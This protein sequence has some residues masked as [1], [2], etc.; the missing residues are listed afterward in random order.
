M[1]TQEA[2][3]ISILDCAKKLGLKFS[4]NYTNTEGL[5][6]YIFHCP[7]RTDRNAS[8]YINE[9]KNVWY[10]NGGITDGGG[11]IHFINYLYGNSLND[12]KSALKVLN[13]I[14]PE[15][16]HPSKRAGQT[17]GVKHISQAL[18]LFS[19][20]TQKS[21]ITPAE[22]YNKK[23]KGA[24]F[25]LVEVKEIFSYPLKNYLQEDRKINIDIAKTHI[26]EIVYKHIEKNIEFY[27]IGFKSGDTWVIR[28]KQFKGFLSKGADI[29]LIDNKTD[30]ILLFEGFIDFLSYLTAKRIKQPQSSV[31]VLNSAIFMNRA[32]DF[33]KEHDN[34]KSI[35]YFRDRDETGEQSLDRLEKALNNV[36][37][38]DKSE[39][40]PN[41]KDLNEWLIHEYSRT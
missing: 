2:F 35:D 34:I 21:E 38:R 15:L 10:D 40:Y 41:H 24:V 8:I 28:R 6:E 31:I 39:V 12:T 11:I 5:V 20:H 26:K 36:I 1:R 14:Y 32:I 22:S 29:T 25:K 16:K 7:L 9:A 23:E 4:H 13:T 19:K 37:I 17:T 30:N 18:P 3:T 33:I 27:G